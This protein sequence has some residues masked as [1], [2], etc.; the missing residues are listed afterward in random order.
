MTVIPAEAGTQCFIFIPSNDRGVALVP[1]R[2]TPLIIFVCE[3][4]VTA[5]KEPECFLTIESLYLT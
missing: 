2:W 1:N 4:D 3:D 5:G